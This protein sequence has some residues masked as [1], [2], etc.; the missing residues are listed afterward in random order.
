MKMLT[1]FIPPSSGRAFIND[2]DVEL[3]A[4]EVRKQ[5]GYLPEHNPLYTDMYVKEY[6]QFIASIYKLPNS[7]KRVAEMIELTGLQVEQKKKIGQLS[8]GYR[9]RV[10][11]AQA[12]IHNPSVLILDEPTSGL[13]PNQI[14]E[15]RN[16]ITT[17]G[18]EKTVLLSTHIMQEVEAMCSRVMIINKGQIVANGKPE[19]LKQQFSSDIML[20]VKFN[21]ALS[22]AQLKELRGFGEVK[23][24]AGAEYQL[25]GKDEEA[26]KALVFNFAVKNQLMLS[27]M[28]VNE[29]S[30]EDIFKNVTR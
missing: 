28:K 21:Q 9:Q 6:L 29:N 18:K 14:V 13:D 19:E 30:L 1:C 17:I 23:P 22:D 20:M 15:I 4:I 11:L 24:I 26:M 5:I 3:Q 25:V 27:E 2:M 12:M 8:K 10:G 7:T 16:L